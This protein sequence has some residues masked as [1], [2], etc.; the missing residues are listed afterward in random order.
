MQDSSLPGKTTSV[1]SPCQ[2]R[3]NVPVTQSPNEQSRHHTTSDLDRQRVVSSY[4]AGNTISNIAE[5][6]GL[7]NPTVTGII[8]QYQ[9]D[10][11]ISSLPRGGIRNSKLNEQQKDL[12]KSWIDED[13]SLS[14]KNIKTKIFEDLNIII[15]PST[16][17]RYIDNFHYSLKRVS[18]VPIR[19]N[20]PETLA[21]RR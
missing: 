6:M 5:V 12:I 18:I 19:R 3:P 21:L 4:L 2:N 10:G 9:R 7:K 13:C 14:L 20:T 11:R 1:V 15:S 8:K 16:I 17:S